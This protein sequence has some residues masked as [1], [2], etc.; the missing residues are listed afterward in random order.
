MKKIWQQASAV[1]SAISD[2]STAS[3]RKASS[4]L[5]AI[6]RNR[7][8]IADHADSVAKV[9][10]VTA[11]VAYVGAAIAAPSGITA[12]G[13]AIGVVSAPLIVSV[14]PYLAGAAGAALTVSA[15]ASVYA[16]IRRRNSNS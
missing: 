9:A 7:E 13:V 15:G 11:G 1:S 14:A 2:A 5:Q 4:A 8:L 16:K 10:K 3:L 12:L 6:D